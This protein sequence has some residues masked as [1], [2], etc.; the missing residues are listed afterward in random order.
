MILIPFR[1]YRYLL[2]GAYHLVNKLIPENEYL[3]HFN[4]LIAIKNDYNKL[5]VLIYQE[6][7]QIK[8]LKFFLNRFLPEQHQHLLDLAFL[9][10][11]DLKMHYYTTFYDK[12]Q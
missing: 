3:S 2:H 4:E 6:I 8:E 9:E 5:D 12:Y 1:Q 11:S 10:I 7:I